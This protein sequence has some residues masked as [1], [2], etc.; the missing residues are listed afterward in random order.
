LL[1]NSL[2]EKIVGASTIKEAWDILKKVFKGVNRVKQMHLQTLQ[3]ELEAMKMKD[4]EDVSS[5]ITHIQAVSNQLKHNG[6]TLT[7]VRVAEKI[8]QSLTDD[9]EIVVCA[10]KEL[11]NLEEMTINDILQTKMGIK[12][13]K[14]M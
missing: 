9:F 5:Y 8:L 3:G 4:S 11:I 2:F 10:I 14:V 13:D 7:D 6:K 12:E 1:I